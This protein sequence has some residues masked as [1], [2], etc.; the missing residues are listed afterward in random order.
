MNY[1]GEPSGGGPLMEL[2]KNRDS[3]VER[4]K[5]LYLCFRVS[6]V[7]VAVS[8]LLGGLASLVFGGVRGRNAAVIFLGIGI[9]TGIVLAERCRRAR[10]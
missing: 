9:L 3:I 6:L 1:C 7:P 4:I 5:K 2:D 8:L 10:R